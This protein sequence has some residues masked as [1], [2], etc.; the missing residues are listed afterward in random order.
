VNK[1]PKHTGKVNSVLKLTDKKFYNYVD[2]NS[3]N[4]FNTKWQQCSPQSCAPTCGRKL[5]CCQ[6]R[7]NRDVQPTPTVNTK[8]HK[9][10]FAWWLIFI[11][12]NIYINLYWQNITNRFINI[13]EQISNFVKWPILSG[14]ISVWLCP[15]KVHYWELL[16]QN[17]IQAE[18]KLLSPN[19][20]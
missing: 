8:C 12:N 20:N 5:S 6:S 3:S 2:W 17:I 15:R 13:Y 14:V 16:D 9:V 4:T 11:I 10:H 1:D 7:R 19:C 18:I